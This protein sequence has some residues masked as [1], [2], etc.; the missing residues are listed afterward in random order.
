MKAF[1]TILLFASLVWGQAARPGQ[2]EK[3]DQAI[4][5]ARQ[6]KH[7]RALDEFLAIL[8]NDPGNKQV[9]TYVAAM[10]FQT[11][12]VLECLAR[13]QTLLKNDPKNPDLLELLGQSYMSTREWN[14]AEAA[15]R[16][17]LKERPDSEQAHMQLGAVLLQNN[18]FESALFEINRSLE[19]NPR[20]TDI[21]SLRGNILASLGRMDEAAQEWVAALSGDPNDSVALSG[22]AVFLRNSDPDQA[23]VYARR[24]VDL[25][26][27]RT[28][29]PYRVLALVYR[30]RGEVAQARQVLERAMLS[31]PSSEMLAAELRSLRA[32]EPANT[33]TLPA[34]GMT[35]GAS[36]R[37]LLALLKL[38]NPPRS[39]NPPPRAPAPSRSRPA[40]ASPAP[41]SL[42]TQNPNLARGVLPLSFIV[43]PFIYADVVAPPEKEIPASLADVAKRLREQKEREKAK[44]KKGT[45]N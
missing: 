30:A 5:L 23:L 25:S 38:P 40:P 15:W 4:E 27:G 41:V 6:Q 22:L 43:P 39:G 29:G 18:R 1:L 36:S 11:G 31:F 13:T 10:E 44:K 20:R 33:P 2:K 8:K 24:A 35:L 7:Q 14:K 42:E 9:A 17:L 21:H 34:E 19:I 45:D 16:A 12:R 26:E 37:D 28:I 32:I 3:I